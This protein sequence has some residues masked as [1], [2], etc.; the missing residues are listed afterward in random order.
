[1]VSFFKL[2]KKK[3]VIKAV[4][5]PEWFI[6]AKKF[7]ISSFKSPQVEFDR[8]MTGEQCAPGRWE[9]KACI[10]MTAAVWRVG[11]WVSVMSVVSKDLLG[12]LCKTTS[13]VR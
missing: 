12:C 1:M 8:K 4:F 3:I 2:K 9:K 10:K 13:M 11:K 7:P 6:E 5:T